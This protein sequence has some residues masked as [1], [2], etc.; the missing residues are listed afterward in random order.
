MTLTSPLTPQEKADFLARFKQR[1]A[2]VEA[3]TAMCLHSSQS[4]NHLSL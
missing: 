3:K 4:R 2:K 1:L